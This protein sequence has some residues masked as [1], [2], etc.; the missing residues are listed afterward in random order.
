MTLDGATEGGNDYFAIVIGMMDHLNNIY[1]VDSWWERET[2][3]PVKFLDKIVEMYFK[4][5]CVKFAGQ[6]SLIEKMLMS[7]LK[8]KMR[9]DKIYL[10]WEALGKNTRENK[11]FPIKKLQPWYEA[12]CVWHNI[13]LEDTEFENEL[14]RFPKAKHDDLPD[15]EQ[16]LLEIL[17]PSS[18]VSQSKNYDRNS[19]EMW[20]RRLKRA[21]GS[22]PSEATEGIIDE[23]TY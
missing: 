15:C 9:D 1:I 5:N 2:C 7:F 23:R 19:L 3:D 21:L 20:K 10:C 18:K 4:W 12:R 14:L 11:E 16:M 17:K 13:N 22:M 6:K 8:K